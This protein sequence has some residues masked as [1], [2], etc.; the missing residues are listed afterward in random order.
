MI[1]KTE[2]KIAQNVR[3]PA[4][5]CPESVQAGD[6]GRITNSLCGEHG[7]PTADGTAL[8]D[9]SCRRWAVHGQPLLWLSD[10]QLSPQ[11]LQ[12][13]Y[14]SRQTLPNSG[15]LEPAQARRGRERLV[16]ANSYRKASTMQADAYLV[17]IF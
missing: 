4:A 13:P 11:Q 1:R 10:H 2:D 15:L 6:R 16:A 7:H 9:A 5:A 3:V 14:R 8:C 12:G 17:V